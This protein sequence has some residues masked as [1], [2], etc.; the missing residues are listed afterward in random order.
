M[1][2]ENG[3]VIFSDDNI[4]DYGNLVLIQHPNN[5]ISVYGNNYSNYVK[6]GQS[7]RKGELLAAV[8]ETNG[9]QPRL[10]FEIRYKGKAQDPFLYFK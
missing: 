6:K 7:I 1:A 2:I 5:I 10:Y 3:T 8:G 4:A 9:N